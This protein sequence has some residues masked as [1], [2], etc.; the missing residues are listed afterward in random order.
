MD[1][2]FQNIVSLIQY[3]IHKRYFSGPKFSFL[4]TGKTHQNLHNADLHIT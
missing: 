4:P 3:H 1:Q 2:L